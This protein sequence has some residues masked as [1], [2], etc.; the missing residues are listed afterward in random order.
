M[1]QAGKAKAILIRPGRYSSLQELLNLMQDFDLQ[2]VGEWCH[3]KT[4]GVP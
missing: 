3:V 2:S 4:T 1:C